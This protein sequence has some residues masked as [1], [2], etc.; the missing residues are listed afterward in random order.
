MTIDQALAG[1]S[2]SVVLTQAAV[3]IPLGYHADRGCY[4]FASSA[5]LPVRAAGM[6]IVRFPRR[7]GRLEVPSGTTDGNVSP[8]PHA[9]LGCAAARGVVD[10]VSGACGMGGSAHIGPLVDV[11]RGR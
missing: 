8:V 3:L 6:H 4:L 1:V 5:S 2:L 9:G 7:L 11:A 10:A